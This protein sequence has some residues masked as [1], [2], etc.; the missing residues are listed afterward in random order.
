VTLIA[1]KHPLKYQIVNHSIYGIY[2]RIELRIADWLQSAV[3]IST[4]HSYRLTEKDIG[5]FS[6][7]GD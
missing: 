1:L 2:L 3:R 4:F 7:G 6:L 5:D